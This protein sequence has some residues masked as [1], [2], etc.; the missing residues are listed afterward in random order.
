MRDLLK[1]KEGE[2]LQTV[3]FATF[4]GQTK[5]NERLFLGKNQRTFFGGGGMHE[6]HEG[7]LSPIPPGCYA[8][9][10]GGINMLFISSNSL[11]VIAFVRATSSRS[12]PLKAT[13]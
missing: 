10:H 1:K 12:S 8:S 6:G 3:F 4:L 11:L 9:D 5:K 2:H 7:I 13:P